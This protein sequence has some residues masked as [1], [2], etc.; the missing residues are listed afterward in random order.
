MPCRGHAWQGGMHGRDM[1]GRGSSITGETATAAD[2]TP[3][4]R[5]H[6]C[7]NL[8]IRGEKYFCVS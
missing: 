4:T 6:S 3:P 7:V 5:M 1:H 8:I 2:S